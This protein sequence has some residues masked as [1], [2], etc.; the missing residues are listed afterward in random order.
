MREIRPSGSEGGGAVTRLS[1]PLSS[2]PVPQRFQ[3]HPNHLKRDRR[4]EP[5]VSEV[6]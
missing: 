1:L 2:T 5:T 3:L 4:P 6:L